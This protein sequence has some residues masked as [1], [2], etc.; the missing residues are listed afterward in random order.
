MR[1]PPN[2][3][4]S[5][6]LPAG[7]PLA[8]TLD[9]PHPPFNL[10]HFTVHG[11]GLISIT[12]PSRDF[13]FRQAAAFLRE[14]CFGLPPRSIAATLIT[15]RSPGMPSGRDSWSIAVNADVAFAPTSLGHDIPAPARGP[16]ALELVRS[17]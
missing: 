4:L 8:R 7:A 13:V 15:G 11:A 9:H 16:P 12:G 1:T 17:R 5:F 3:R 10:M 14:L 6:L 2:V